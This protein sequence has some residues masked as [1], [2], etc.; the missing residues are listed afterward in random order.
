MIQ[1]TSLTKKISNKVLLS[2]L[3]FTLP[4]GKLIG[5]LGPNGAGKTTLLRCLAGIDS[6]HSGDVVIDQKSMATLG[7]E[8]RAKLI[9]W[10]PAET[11]I[12]FSFAT[13]DILM[14]GRYPYHHGNPTPH[15]QLRCQQVFS[16]LHIEHLKELP[17]T[18]LSSGELKKIHLGRTLASDADVLI[19][20]EPIVHL[21]VA[22]ALF[23]CSLFRK[24]SDKGKTIIVSLHDLSLASRFM[25]TCLLIDKGGLVALGTTEEVLSPERIREVFDV[26]TTTIDHGGHRYLQFDEI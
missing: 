24:L 20:D 16:E 2:N 15:D 25:D 18:A 6:D 17:V 9:A 19:F 8:A 3:N 1:V 23:F 13:Q 10:A 12:P 11:D 5:V 22:S 26:K 4:K 7:I 14:F 21:D